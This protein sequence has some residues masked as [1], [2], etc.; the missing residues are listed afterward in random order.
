L[1]GGRS[2]AARELR[3][4]ENARSRYGSGRLVIRVGPRPKP[5]D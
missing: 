5:A 1:F 4:N 3:Q 2:S